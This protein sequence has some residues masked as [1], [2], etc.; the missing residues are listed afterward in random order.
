M[1][2]HISPQRTRLTNGHRL[3]PPVDTAFEPLV[4]DNVPYIYVSWE[5]MGEYTFALAQQ[6]LASGQDFD[7][8]VALAKGGWTWVRTLSDYLRIDRVSSIRFKSY[9]NIG[10]NAKLNM[11]QPLTESVTGQRVLIFDDVADSGQTVKGA[12]AYLKTMGAKK[13]KIAMLCYKPRSIIKPDFYAFQTPAWVV[14]PHEVREFVDLSYA[15]WMKSGLTQKE[16][17]ERFAA[18]GVPKTQVEYFIALQ[19]DKKS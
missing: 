17:R 11:V 12:K 9:T 2:T 8:I 4:F 3:V 16:I 1:Q 19:N 14:F 18:I 15:K 6:I 13:V 5:R 10:E 7:C